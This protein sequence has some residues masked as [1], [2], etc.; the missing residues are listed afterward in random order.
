MRSVEGFVLMRRMAPS[1]IMRTLQMRR[2]AAASMSS[3]SEEEDEEEGEGVVR[4]GK[5]CFSTSRSTWTSG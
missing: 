2:R 5:E 3:V 4:M 1:L